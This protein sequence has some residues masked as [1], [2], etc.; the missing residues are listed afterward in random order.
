VVP[1]RAPVFVVGHARERRDI[2]AAEIA[3]HPTAPLYLISTHPQK[4]VSRG[5]RLKFWGFGVLGFVLAAAFLAWREHL[6]HPGVHSRFVYQQ[7]AVIY[8]G[9]WLLGW[10]WMAFNSLVEL[11][12][13]VAQGWANI[14]VELK[15]RADLLPNI[16]KL[17][18]ALR[19]HEAR[20]Q[21]ELAALRAQAGATAPGKAGPDPAAAAG[22]LRAIA[23]AYPELKASQAFL[24]LQKQLADTEDRIA[25]ARGYFNEIATFYNTRIR[26]FPDGLVAMLIGMRMR[27]LMKAEGFERAPVRAGGPS[28]SAPR[29]P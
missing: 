2:V 16:V 18:S 10:V 29:P 11:R 7:A 17:V 13:R 24:R 26:S 12:Q 3:A 19:D 8:A 21:A 22:P 25:L 23:E 9:A 4:D 6:L 5:L 28:A 27:P 15:R 1:L 14:D 20:V